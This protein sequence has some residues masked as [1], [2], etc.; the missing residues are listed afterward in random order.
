MK[1]ADPEHREPFRHYGT[2]GAGTYGVDA[3]TILLELNAVWLAGN[4]RA[5]RPR[6]P[7]SG[8]TGTISLTV[9]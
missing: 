5:A 2:T 1:R 9:S 8:H 4:G 7:D 6:K 3:A